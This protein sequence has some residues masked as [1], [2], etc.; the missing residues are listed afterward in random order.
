MTRATTVKP[1]DYGQLIDEAVSY[2]AASILSDDAE[3]M[4]R[5]NAVLLEAVRLRSGC[6]GDLVDST[7]AH[8]VWKDMVAVFGQR[9]TPLVANMGVAERLFGKSLAE[10]ETNLDEAIRSALA[11]VAR[12][13]PH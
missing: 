12:P 4:A 3:N 1:S 13:P 11:K 8:D 6:H 7:I 2:F 10:T 5:V 9:V